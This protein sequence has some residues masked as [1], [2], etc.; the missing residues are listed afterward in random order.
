MKKVIPAQ[1]EPDSTWS[2]ATWLDYLLSIHPK[3]IEMGLD[4]VQLVFDKLNL[5]LTGSTIVSVAG[6]N[7][8][9]TTCALIEHAVLAAGK[10]VAVYS[11]PHLINYQERVRIN[12]KQLSA[13]AH[14]NAFLRIEE[15]RGDVLL[16][17]FEFA[18]LAALY[19]ISKHTCEIVLLEVGLGGRLDAVNIVDPDLAVITSIGIDHQ[20]FLG[21]TREL[22]AIEKAGI[23]RKGIP[24]VIGEIDPPD[25]LIEQAKNINV[26]SYWQGKDFNFVLKNGSWNWSGKDKQLSNLPLPL[27][28]LQ[29]VST[30]LQVIELLRLPL[31][32]LALRK[33]IENTSLP[34]RYQKIQT[35]P[36]V[37]LDVAHN[38][39]AANNLVT[40][41]NSLEFENLHLVVA[42]LADK[43]IKATLEPFIAQNAQW[44]MASLDNPR[45]ADSELLKSVLNKNETVLEFESV[46]KAY[47]QAL[48]V[49]DKKDLVVVFG[50]FFTVANVLKNLN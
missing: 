12:H 28:P 35:D 45:G 21:D 7:G 22:I 6:T 29:N 14:C 41:L 3:N 25:T 39:Q 43:D 50:S 24:A 32:S 47:N 19:L 2:L 40:Y 15:A 1:V 37:I 23:F 18:T 4:R 49:A 36:T 16:T 27:I 34:G 26:S 17:F 38:P 44:Y 10:S 8:K 9:G 42:M 20:E 33:V 5:D 31:S 30:A 11:S 46:E 13:S 48:S